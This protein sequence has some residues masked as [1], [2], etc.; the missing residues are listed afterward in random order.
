MEQTIEQE[1]QNYHFLFF[2]SSSACSWE[3]SARRLKLGDPR[4]REKILN[5]VSRKKNFFVEMI[6]L[7]SFVLLIRFFFC[8]WLLEQSRTVYFQIWR[9]EVSDEARSE[10]SSRIIK[11]FELLLK[12]SRFLR[13]DAKLRFAP[14]SRLVSLIF[15]AT[16]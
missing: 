9:N 8:S 16:K 4:A 2:R 12:F 6:N 15:R 13:F 5:L 14:F 7:V 11:I 1:I 10:F 3:K